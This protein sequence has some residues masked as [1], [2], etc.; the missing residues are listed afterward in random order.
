VVIVLD[1]RL[2]AFDP[3]DAENALVVHMNMFVVMQV[4]VDASVAFIR[5]LHVDLL[6]LLCYLL[7]LH[8]PGA[9]RS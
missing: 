5:A 1:G 2:D 8:G 7:I 9:Q 3:A 6:Y 4:V